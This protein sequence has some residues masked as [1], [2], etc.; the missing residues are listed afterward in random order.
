MTGPEALAEGFAAQ[1]C[2]WSLDRGASATIAAAAGQA[3]RQLSLATAAGV[4][5]SVALPIAATAANVAFFASE[6]AIT[7]GLQYVV[8]D[9][10][11]QKPAPIGAEGAPKAPEPELPGWFKAMMQ[12]GMQGGGAGG[13]PKP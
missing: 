5:A 13:P 4:S 11:H 12:G 3:A 1:V 10:A 9:I 6:L 8:D 2:R 7:V